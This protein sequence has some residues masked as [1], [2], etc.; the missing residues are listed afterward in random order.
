MR[1][2][3]T[4]SVSYAFSRSRSRRV[5]ASRARARAASTSV[6]ENSLVARAR[7][8]SF[9]FVVPPRAPSRLRVSASA[10]A[11]DQ[12]IIARSARSTDARASSR[13]PRARHSK[14]CP[15][16]RIASAGVVPGRVASSSS[17][18][19]SSSRTVRSHRMHNFA[20]SAAQY[21]R[22]VATSHATH[23]APH[24]SRSSRGGVT[25]WLGPTPTQPLGRSLGVDVGVVRGRRSER[26]RS[27]ECQRRRRDRRRVGGVLV[28]G[29]A[30]VERV[31]ARE[32]LDD[33]GAFG[34]RWK[35]RRAREAVHRQSRC[36]NET[37]VVEGWWWN[38]V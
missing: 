27:R 23:A 38:G 1:T 3:C 5:P 18:S 24:R 28:G 13:T 8:A 10:V 16:A 25:R 9:P 15:L 26:E 36:E 32:E 11:T 14:K 30:R 21:I 35:L 29:V 22:A 4:T 12:N 6:S 19:S 34:V 31:G 33:V 7:G 17:S 37:H 20:S 2:P